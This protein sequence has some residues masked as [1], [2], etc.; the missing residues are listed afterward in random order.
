M[1]KLLVVSP[2]LL[3]LGVGC[4]STR[5]DWTYCDQTYS[6]CEKGFTCNLQ[7][8]L[9]IRDVDAGSRDVP[10]AGDDAKPDA[11]PAVDLG[12]DSKDAP[13]VPDASVDTSIVDVNPVVDLSSPDLRVPDAA[14]TCSVDND[15]TGLAAGAYCVNNRCAA[16][17]TSSQCNNDAG[18]PFCSAQHTCVSCSSAGSTGS[19]DGGIDGGVSGPCSGA[20]PACNASTGS[21]VQCVKNSDCPTAS[22]AFCVQNQCVGCDSPGASCASG[23]DGGVADA[24][25][26]PTG[27][28]RVC[29]PSGNGSAKAGQCVGCNP[30]NSNDTGCSGNTPI[31]D[32][33]TYTCKPCTSDSQCTTLPG[34]CLFQSGGRCATEGE[35]IYVENDPR[36]CLTT[37]TSTSTAATPF[38]QIQIGLSAVKTDK[39]VVLVK[40]TFLLSPFSADLG[41]G[42]PQVSIIGQN[43]PIVSVGAANA[44]IELISGSLY[45]RG[46]TVQGVGNG[47]NGPGIQVDSSASF[48]GLDRCR[49]LGNAGGLLLNAGVNFDINNSVFAANAS[50]QVNTTTFF[51]GVYLGG[52]APT[53]GLSQ[54][55]FNTIYNN[56]DRG[57]ICADSTQKL[58]G[59]FAYSNQGG[60]YASCVMD[61]TSVWGNGKTAPDNTTSY[62][63]ASSTDVSLVTSDSSYHL[64]ATNHCRDLVDVSTSHPLDDIDGDSRPNPANGK[65]DCGADEI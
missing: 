11:S 64:T 26:G 57:V 19:V 12:S 17:K 39:R 30:D 18:V 50:G 40:G 51:G 58:T 6:V 27:A 31:C 56:S 49:I 8:G 32:E 44:G 13:I 25:S 10:V 54:F 3:V 52:S 53:T 60:D 23:V 15:C 1:R 45:I 43:S 48:I 61:K 37:S 29:V 4:N 33:T 55:R 16:C 2:L 42:T 47:S 46:L 20:T 7:Q 24:G 9:C 62:G 28:G 35:M 65:L 36:K 21:C 59:I 34:I 41:K 38:C 22:K 14:G 5:R 63:N